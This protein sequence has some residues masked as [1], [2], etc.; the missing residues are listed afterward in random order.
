M[1]ADDFGPVLGKPVE[2]VSADHEHKSGRGERY[3]SALV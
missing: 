2:V 3:R 1:A